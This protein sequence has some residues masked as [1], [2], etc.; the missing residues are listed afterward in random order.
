M[1]PA[2]HGEPRQSPKMPPRHPVASFQHATVPVHGGEDIA[3]GC[4]FDYFTAIAVR[5]R[6]QAL[7]AAALGAVLGCAPPSAPHV[8]CRRGSGEMHGKN[9]DGS[10]H[11]IP[12]RL[13]V[14]KHGAREQPLHAELELSGSRACFPYS[15]SWSLLCDRSSGMIA[16]SRIC[17]RNHT[18]TGTV[19]APILRVGSYL[20][21]RV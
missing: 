20:Y 3:S 11:H 5:C 6:Q 18:A 10:L 4:S 2:G 1:P 16:E 7:V 15:S 17:G 19:G 8:R 21:R 14:P 9:E 12:T 13:S